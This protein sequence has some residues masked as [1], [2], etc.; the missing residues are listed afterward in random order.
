MLKK[1][2]VVYRMRMIVTASVLYASHLVCMDNNSNRQL[3]LHRLEDNRIARIDGHFAE[4]LQKYH[5]QVETISAHIYA[6]GDTPEDKALLPKLLQ[7]RYMAQSK[8]D[9]TGIVHHHFDKAL[10]RPGFDARQSASV[11]WG[12]LECL[13]DKEPYEATIDTSPEIVCQVHQSLN[14]YAPQPGSASK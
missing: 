4:H 14:L 8:K 9:V 12:W 13:A 6:L 3:V 11:A 2:C 10:T 7:E 1:I 5:K